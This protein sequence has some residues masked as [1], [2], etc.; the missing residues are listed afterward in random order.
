MICAQSTGTVYKIIWNGMGGMEV[1]QF[2]TGTNMQACNTVYT[3][4]SSRV[5]S[6]S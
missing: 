6:Y 1:G 3:L 5:Y 2:H 4:Y